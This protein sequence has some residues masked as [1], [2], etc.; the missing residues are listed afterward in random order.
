[1]GTRRPPHQGTKTQGSNH[2][3]STFREHV[4]TAMVVRDGMDLPRWDVGSSAF[5]SVRVHQGAHEWAQ[6]FQWPWGRARPIARGA[7]RVIGPAV[8]GHNADADK[9]DRSAVFMEH[10][11]EPVPD[12]RNDR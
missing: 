1:M 5:H 7:H 4:G 3:G 9:V 10:G 2:R 8:L 11:V 6:V 12:T